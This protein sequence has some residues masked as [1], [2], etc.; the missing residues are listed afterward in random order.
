MRNRRYHVNE[1]FFAKMLSEDQAYVLGFTASDGNVSGNCFRYGLAARDRDHLFL[2]RSLLR[3]NHPVTD[4]V[5]D[6]D[7]VDY[8]SCGLQVNSARMVQDLAQLGVFPAKSM[9][10]QPWEGKLWLMRHYWRGMVDGDGSVR[11]NGTAYQIRLCGNSQVVDAFIR[12]VAIRTG[13]LGRMESMKSIFEVRW[14]RFLDVQKIATLLY[15][16]AKFYLARKAKVALEIIQAER[17]TQ[18]W[19][20]VTK[21]DL[22]ALYREHGSWP[23]VG[24]ALGAGPRNIHVLRKRHRIH[25]CP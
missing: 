19:S 24:I 12:F 17:A 4:K 16:N 11:R 18:D 3:S 25:L 6:M 1:S 21:N 22:L 15:G 8:H 10:M 5:Q 14:D 9:T 2:I 13:T 23:A 7:G 20:K